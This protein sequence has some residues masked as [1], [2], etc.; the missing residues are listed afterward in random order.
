MGSGSQTRG[1]AF[2]GPDGTGR[3]PARIK[4]VAVPVL[5]A[6]HPIRML[7]WSTSG[8]RGDGTP[9]AKDCVWEGPPN[10]EW[11]VGDP[12]PDACVALPPGIDG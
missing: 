1:F 12:E 8:G 3:C 2:G 11:C 4:A 7:Y 10:A 9:N 6:R 5:F